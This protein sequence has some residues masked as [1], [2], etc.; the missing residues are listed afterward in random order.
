MMYIV[1]GLITFKM[2]SA[3]VGKIIDLKTVSAHM[4]VTSIASIILSST[5]PPA[6]SEYP[7][8]PVWVATISPS[9]WQFSMGFPSLQSS[10]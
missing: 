7:V 2:I 5:G 6:E 9:A 4:G 10:V 3:S 1:F 8:A